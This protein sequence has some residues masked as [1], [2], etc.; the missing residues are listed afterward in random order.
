MINNFRPIFFDNDWRTPE[1]IEVRALLNWNLLES[2]KIIQANR[3]YGIEWIGKNPS[4]FSFCSSSS[5]DGIV[6][7]A[8]SV[9]FYPICLPMPIMSLYFCFVNKQINRR[10][11]WIE[12]KWTVFCVF[13]RFVWCVNRLFCVLETKVQSEDRIRVHSY[14]WPYRRRKERNFSARSERSLRFVSP[15]IRTDFDMSGKWI[16]QSSKNW[17]LLMRT[18]PWIITTENM[19]WW[20]VLINLE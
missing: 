18:S 1:T 12:P 5:L 10:L 4:S 17:F 16:V 15:L 13:A 3:K 11:T 19:I 20:S 8:D 7:P 2:R 14:V 6:S 9:L